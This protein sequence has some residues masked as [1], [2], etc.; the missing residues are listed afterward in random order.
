VYIT[1][2]GH[3]IKIYVL[4]EIPGGNYL[5][6]TLWYN[7]RR[8][9]YTGAAVLLEKPVSLHVIVH[10]A[11]HVAC[12]IIYW[13]NPRD[14]AIR[15]LSLYADRDGAQE[16]LATMTHEIFEKIVKVIGFNTDNVK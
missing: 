9:R 16:N 1:Y 8:S 5:G 7:H 12:N 3:K 6:L 4:D 2:Q 10:E 13:D 15:L 11:Q 14:K